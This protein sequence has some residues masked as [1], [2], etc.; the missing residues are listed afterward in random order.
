VISLLIPLT[1][2]ALYR[3][4]GW[5]WLLATA[6]VA[7]IYSLYATAGQTAIWANVV[8]LITTIH[9]VVVFGFGIAVGALACVLGWKHGSNV[10]LDINI[11]IKKDPHE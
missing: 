10:V 7:L 11:T 4:D 1:L 9:P 5:P 3:R 6:I 2:Y 8:Q